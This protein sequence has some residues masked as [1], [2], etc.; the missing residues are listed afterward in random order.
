MLFNLAGN[1][2]ILLGSL[3]G[4]LLAVSPYE[5]LMKHRLPDVLHDKQQVCHIIVS[6]VE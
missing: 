2:K 6:S 5:T 3:H 4:T 1:I